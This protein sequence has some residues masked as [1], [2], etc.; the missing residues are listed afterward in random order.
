M[1]HKSSGDQQA[2]SDGKKSEEAYGHERRFIGAGTV[3]TLSL[4]LD[5]EKNRLQCL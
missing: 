5:D 2:A 1:E 3:G 4:S